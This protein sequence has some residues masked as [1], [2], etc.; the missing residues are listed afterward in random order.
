MMLIRGGKQ[1]LSNSYAVAIRRHALKHHIT[2]T[3]TYIASGTCAPQP[4]IRFTV[5][6][7]ANRPNKNLIRVTSTMIRMRA[8]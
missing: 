7:E 2:V 6:T 5:C 1:T 4:L 3:H 8:A